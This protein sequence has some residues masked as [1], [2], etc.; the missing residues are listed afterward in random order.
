MFCCCTTL[1]TDYIDFE[2]AQKET[3]I[4]VSAKIITSGSI[5]FLRYENGYYRLSVSLVSR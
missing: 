4:K 3:L 1:R 5:E 2:S